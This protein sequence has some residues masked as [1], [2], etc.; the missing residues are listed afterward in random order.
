VA[1]GEGAVSVERFPGISLSELDERA[2]LL[3][4]VDHKYVVPRDAFAELLR[5]LAEDH[6]V[7]DVDGR[8]EFAYATVY[9]ETPQ[10]R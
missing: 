3:R 7:L 6:D 9:F 10:L 5:R 2:S 8:R 1:P 4:R